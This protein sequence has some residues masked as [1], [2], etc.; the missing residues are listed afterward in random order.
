[1]N[2]IAAFFAWIFDPHPQDA[3]RREEAYLAQSVDM[4]DLERRMR[5]LDRHRVTEAVIR[6]A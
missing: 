4:C 2:I 5:E 6:T 1:V 3:L